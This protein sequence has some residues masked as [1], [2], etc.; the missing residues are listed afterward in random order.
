MTS[1][2]LTLANY[3]ARTGQRFRMTKDEMARGLT[4]EQAFAER[5]GKPISVEIRPAPVVV[6]PVRNLLLEAHAH[7]LNGTSYS[8]VKKTLGLSWQAAYDLVTTL[9]S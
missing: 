1:E 4:R 6:V 5:Q 9:R 8:K 2:A 7:G 3:Q